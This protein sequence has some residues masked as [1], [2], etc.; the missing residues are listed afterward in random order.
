MYDVQLD[1]TAGPVSVGEEFAVSISLQA[2]GT[3]QGVYFPL[4]IPAGQAESGEL[5]IFLDSRACQVIGSYTASLPLDPPRG[6][7][8]LRP[9]ARFSMT[10]LRPG[11]AKIRAELYVGAGFRHALEGEVWVAGIDGRDRSVA[12]PARPVPQPDFVLRAGTRW[13]EDGSGTMLH[14][15]LD[16]YRTPSL[17]TSDMEHLSEWL[18]IG[19]LERAHGVLAL[20]IDGTADGTVLDARRRLTS[21]G[22]YLYQTA[23][24]PGLQVT[25]RKWAGAGRTMLVVADQGA[26]L[27]W[28]LLHD[29][30]GFLGEHFVIGR[31]PLELD[32]ARPYEFPIGQVSMVHYA[33]V[34]Q[35]GRWANLI[36]PPRMPELQPEIL[37]G[38]VLDLQSAE[39]LRGLHIVRQGQAPGTAGPNGRTGASR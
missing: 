14:Y 11:G 12:V 20:T 37:A 34:E 26:A 19:W 8:W 33:E 32:G 27:P 22:R 28:E 18:P 35:P 9:Q 2:A 25:F 15:R 1:L 5:N 31:W 39:T 13:S 6:K 23:L 10:A 36:R 21:L 30:H 24:P 7:G 3:G 17:P 16:G 29:G 38:G 4:T